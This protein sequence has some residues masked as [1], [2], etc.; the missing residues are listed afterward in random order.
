MNELLKQCK[1]AQMYENYPRILDLTS[2]ILKT[3]PQNQTAIGYRSFAYLK[4]GQYTEAL[5]LLD[6]GCRLYPDNYYLKNNLAMLYY[7]LGE[8]EKSLKCCEE[9]LEIKEFDWLCKNKILALIKLERIAEAIEFY[10][11][12]SFYTSLEEVFGDIKKYTY[13]VYDLFEVDYDECFEFMDRIKDCIYNN[14][15]E[16]LPVIKDFYIGWIYK[17]KKVHDT[18][19]C[20]DCGG[21]IVPII[22]GYPA[23]Y[24]LKKDIDGEIYL[25]GCVIP[26]NPCNF[27]CKSCGHEFDL[28][29]EGIEIEIC[30][31]MEYAECKL[32]E[33][34][35]KLM[36]DSGAIVKSVDELK[37]ELYGF[38]D[39]EFEA[40]ISHLKEIDLICEPQSGHVK[41]V[42]FD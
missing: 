4:L 37:Y 12:V 11:S 5:N 41:L 28:G 29:Y 10:E 21:E 13:V 16:K 40:F 15:P 32:D 1:T 35:I 23:D 18:K 34:I 26:P 30:D 2:E 19:I 38:D 27:H 14:C 20:P 7:D 8:Y 24:L 39:S 36:D 25:G 6:E 33:L 31:E 17:I 22:W 3:N 9:G 42:E